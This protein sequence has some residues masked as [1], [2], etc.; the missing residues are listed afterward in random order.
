[1]LNIL[2]VALRH[3]SHAKHNFL[4]LLKGSILLRQSCC[5]G[6]IVLLHCKLHAELQNEAHT[7]Y[8][9][10]IGIFIKFLSILIFPHIS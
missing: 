7:Y 10:L 4:A 9:P 6:D 5:L 3:K 8:R 1:M 2:K